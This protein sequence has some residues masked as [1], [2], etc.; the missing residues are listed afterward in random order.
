MINPRSLWSGAQVCSDIHQHNTAGAASSTAVQA[1][2]IYHCGPLSPHPRLG[3]TLCTCRN[4]GPCHARFRR[5][6]RAADRS[7]HTTDAETSAWIRATTLSAPRVTY[8]SES[9]VSKLKPALKCSVS[10]EIAAQR[11][12]PHA[13][14][15]AMAGRRDESK[16]ARKRAVA[17][18]KTDGYR[19]VCSPCRLWCRPGP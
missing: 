4:P 5:G 3:W 18:G 1:T 10:I 19:F 9:N 14:Y 8:R 7:T 6:R 13:N 16:L 15:S 17:A 12:M 2:V 11:R